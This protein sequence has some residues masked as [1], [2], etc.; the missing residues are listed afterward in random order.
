MAARAATL[1]NQLHPSHARVAILANDDV[2]IELDPERFR[3]LGD[4]FCH[5]DV[6]TR[7]RRIAGRMVMHQ[8]SI[9][10]YR[11]EPTGIFVEARSRWGLGLGSVFRDPS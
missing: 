7:G 5:V 4:L 8:S 10:A 9:S 1:S 2:V 11:I 3:D 6:G